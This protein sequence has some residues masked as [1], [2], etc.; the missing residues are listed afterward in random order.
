[1]IRGKPVRTTIGDKATPCPLDTVNRQLQAPAP[2]RLW[3]SDFTYG[4]TWAG[5]LYVA[6]LIGVD[7]RYI[8]G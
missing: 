6:F 8:V 1:M 4:A 2:S 5:F 3:V 7:A